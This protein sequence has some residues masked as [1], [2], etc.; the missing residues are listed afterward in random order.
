MF[1]LNSCLDLFSAPPRVTAEDPFSRSY[2]V[3]LPSSLTVSLSSALVFSTPDHLCRFAVRAEGPS[4]GLRGFSREHAPPQLS[5]GPEGPPVLSGL[6]GTVSPGPSRLTPFNAL[7]GQRACV[8]LL[9]LPRDLRTSGLRNIDR[10]SIRTPHT[11]CVRPRLTL[12]RLALFR[13]PWS[14]GEGVSRP[15][16][17][18]LCLHLLFHLLQ[19]GSRHPFAAEGEARALLEAREKQM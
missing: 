13:N 5:A 6:A 4:N 18:Y 11:G 1:L 7:F 10:I 14:S 9:R 8:S 2:G 17:R 3:S 15:L 16:C 19:N 12:N